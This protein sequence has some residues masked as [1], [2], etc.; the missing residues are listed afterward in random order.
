VAELLKG[1]QACINL[2]GIIKETR[3]VAT[4]KAVTFRKSHVEATRTLVAG[5]LEGGVRRYIQMSALGVTPNGVSEYQKTKFEAENIVRLS[6]LEWTIVRPGLVHGPDGEFVH[7]I[8]DM[9]TG[10]IPPYFFAPYFQRSVEDKR[11]PMGS[12]TQIDPKVQ[13]VAVEDVAAAFVASLAKPETIGEVYNLVGSEVL[14]WPTMIR[15]MRDA[16]HAGKLEPWGIPAE[17]AAIGATV[18]G[19]LGFG[20]A[21]PFD[22]G[23]AR[24]A[25]QDATASLD[26]VRAEL[27]IEPKPFRATFTKYASAV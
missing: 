19:K 13:P 27:G 3:N 23:M 6:T 12:V 20:S 26:K 11:V 15:F 1:C 9:L 4:G 8:K 10:Q 25:A 24:M 5:C 2:V 21:L 22:A 16:M 18:A 17:V 7:L 14:E